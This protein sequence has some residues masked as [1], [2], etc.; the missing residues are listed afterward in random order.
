M[1]ETKYKAGR[2]VLNFLNHMFNINTCWRKDAMLYLQYEHYGSQ[3]TASQTYSRI[4]EQGLIMEYEPITPSYEKSMY[5][6]SKLDEEE[7]EKAA[8]DYISSIVLKPSEKPGRSAYAV[9]QITEK[10]AVFLMDHSDGSEGW[11][12]RMR[13]NGRRFRTQ[14][15]DRV[16]RQ[17]M[18]SRA[19]T[20]FK[21]ADTAVYISEKP[22]LYRLYG[23][24]NHLGKDMFDTSKDTELFPEYPCFGYSECTKLL[25][26]K[27]VFYTAA[28]VRSFL[29]YLRVEDSD[30]LRSSRFF[31]FY[32]SM[33]NSCIVYMEKPSTNKFIKIRHP[34]EERLFT[35]IRSY[36]SDATFTKADTMVITDG[37]SQMYSMSAGVKSARFR[38]NIDSSDTEKVQEKIQS[39]R[40]N[41]EVL[42]LLIA[43][44]KISDNIYAV[45][46]RY[47]GITSLEY[48]CHHD[49]MDYYS[50]SEQLIKNFPNFCL[51]DSMMKPHSFGH[52][53]V[54]RGMESYQAIFIPVFD[55]N[56]MREMSIDEDDMDNPKCYAIITL[57]ELTD[58]ISHALRKPCRYYDAFTGNKI[59]IDA[60]TGRKISLSE[61]DRQMVS[62]LIQA[63]KVL[64]RGEVYTVLQLKT[65]KDNP[66]DNLVKLIEMA[67]E[68]EQKEL[69]EKKKN[70]AYQRKHMPKD[71][72]IYNAL[73]RPVN[74]S[75][76]YTAIT[77]ARPKKKHYKRDDTV[78]RIHLS[79]EEKELYQKVARLLDISLSR[80]VAMCTIPFAKKT[81]AL[82]KEGGLSAVHESESKK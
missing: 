61:Q 38:G 75:D 79:R 36:F 7:I 13:E 72:T 25:E 47:D 62:D 24:I 58:A 54:G 78:I 55:V 41:T 31:G 76:P 39:V 33:K 45:P 57:P 40:K 22:S 60:D 64:G 18:V 15:W 9:V 20:M 82:S 26:N 56:L 59:Y 69:R 17:L 52:D 77:K 14:N 49:L 70:L 35:R 4:L 19:M 1:T 29:S 28:E 67:D 34:V 23:M 44:S 2:A 32:I 73:G 10:G 81:L 5:G 12:G 46:S 53:I 8:K 48:Y 21:C 43:G 50:D 37:D 11:R 51:F 65:L 68:I 6:V 66:S 80:L 16:I 27:G 42:S 74:K 3:S 30:P 63:N 71:I